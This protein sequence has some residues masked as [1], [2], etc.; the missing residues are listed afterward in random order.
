MAIYTVAKNIRAEVSQ[1][2]VLNR[3][4]ETPGVVTITD[5]RSGLSFGLP[6]NVEDAKNIMDA[7]KQLVSEDIGYK[8]VDVK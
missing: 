8:T 5:R 3:S 7:W 4:S 1:N 2:W 6:G